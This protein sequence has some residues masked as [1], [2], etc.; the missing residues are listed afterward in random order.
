MRPSL[1]RHSWAQMVLTV[2]I[3]VLA[4][5]AA[6]K[7]FTRIDLSRDRLYSLDEASKVIVKQLDRPLVVKVYITPGLEAPYNNH[8]QIVADKLEEYRAYAGGQMSVVTVDPSQDPKAAEEAGRYGVGQLEYTVRKQ[9][10]AEL[11]KIWMGMVL[12]YGDRQEVL[13]ALSDLSSLEYDISSALHRLQVKVADRKTIGWTLGHGEPDYTKEQGPVRGIVEQLARK[14]DVRPVTLGGPGGIPEEVDALLVVGPQQPIG[15]RGLYQLDQ[16]VM[17][18]GALAVF[19][20]STRPDMRTLRATTVISG[21][22]PLL[23]HFGIRANRDVVIDRVDNGQLRFPVRQAGKLSLRDINHPAILKSTELSRTS[24]LTAGLDSMV[25]PFA[26]SLDLGEPIPGVR[27]E[28]LA[29]SGKASGSIPS[30][31]SLD[32][33]LLRDVQPDE[34]RG[35]FDILV[36]A[37]GN[38]RSFYETRAV[39]PADADAPVPEEPVEEPTLIVEGATTRLI[40]AGS[41]DFI[42]N[43]AAFMLNLVDWLV[44]DEALIGIRSKIAALPALRATTSEEQNGW[45]A[46]H[47][48]T[49]P[50]LL[51]LWGGWRQLRRRRRASAA[52]RRAA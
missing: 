16:F 10:R 15:D 29:R 30:L 14:Y 6:S 5:L 8:A 17:R 7:H 42:A 35:P 26:S 31:K 24:P 44:Q 39:P 11:R 19:L 25:F 2:L 4:N 37:Y 21:L 28:A 3:V 20:T 43:N 41:A 9:D 46:F 13:P 48:L 51:L 47:L 32:P 12:L 34:K 49:G 1:L 45:R 18:G 38:F 22:D 40:V 50:A 27:Y 33:S 52:S 36:S 23:G